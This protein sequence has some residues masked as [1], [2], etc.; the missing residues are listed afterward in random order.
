MQLWSKISYKGVWVFPVIGVGYYCWKKYLFPRR[1]I[2]WEEICCVILI[3]FALWV[4]IYSTNYMQYKNGR[5]KFTLLS[6]F[7]GGKA[8]QW[9]EAGKL[10][11]QRPP[12]PSEMCFSKPEG[13]LFGEFE[14]KYVCKPLAEDGHIFIIGGSGSGKSS[15]IIIDSLALNPAVQKLVMD[16]KGELSFK[17]C[18]YD[19]EKTA[20]L[21]PSNRNMWGYNPF[22]ALND[23]STVQQIVETMQTIALSLIPLP[24][25]TKDP[26]WKQSARN[27]ILSLLLYF[28]KNGETEFIDIVDKILGKPIQELVQ[29]VVENSNSDSVEYRYIIQFA[30]LEIETLGSIFAELANH[31]SIFVNDCNLRYAFKDNPLR[32]SPLLL[33]E[34]YSVYL[35]IQEHKLGAYSEVLQLIL[36]QTF[37]ELEQRPEDS[38]PIL[39][40]IDELPRLVSQGKIER[41]LDG[42]RTL[43]SRKVHLC[44]VSQSLEALQTAY[45]KAE[46]T[47][48]IGN[49]SYIY[50]LNAKSHE[51]IQAIVEWCGKYK[52]RKTSWNNG[53]SNGTSVSYEEKN[54][55][56]GSDLITLHKTGEAILISPHGYH[57]VTKIPWYEHKR[58]KKIVSN[59]MKHNK[60]ILDLNKEE[61]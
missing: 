11:A 7:Y 14:K 51:T 57:R 47:D 53:K 42:A 32:V 5:R 49:C 10:A 8:N 61:K 36:N 33:E 2:T 15:T 18:A 31:I 46:V 26:F 30:G 6:A 12:V 45:S 29:E 54:I 9:N 43:R 60:A 20:I 24:A 17:S 52:A 16:I 25:D 23:S 39:F 50:V 34:G 56:D 38:E 21:N 58:F 28:Y 41:L 48:L 4:F 59:N 44:L 3:A 27:L 35:S 55:V 37:Y 19:G 13:I 40:V 1:E 22:Y